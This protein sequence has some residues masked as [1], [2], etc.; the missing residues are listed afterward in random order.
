MEPGNEASTHSSI[1]NTR[2]HSS[3]P[4]RLPP[5]PTKSEVKAKEKPKKVKKTKPS[6]QWPPPQDP[7]SPAVIQTEPDE[8]P[9][10]SPAVSLQE[11][12]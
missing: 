11:G 12:G 5:P 10:Y 1:H 8:P 6:G 9:A 4:P 3:Q 2:A 7:S